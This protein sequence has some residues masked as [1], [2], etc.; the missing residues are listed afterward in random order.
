[1]ALD[2]PNSV[3]LHL[4][5]VGP[6]LSPA[7]LLKEGRMAKKELPDY[8]ARALKEAAPELGTSPSTLNRARSHGLVK[9]VYI[10]TRPIIPADEFERLK[11]EGLPRIPREYKRLTTGPF[12]A[13]RKRKAAVPVPA[14]GRRK[15]R[16]GERR[17]TP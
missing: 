8:R 14:K 16:D 11:R 6:S 3:S 13:G 15:P 12:L 2:T 7:Y 9:V 4:T 5:L 17:V 10:G 1:M